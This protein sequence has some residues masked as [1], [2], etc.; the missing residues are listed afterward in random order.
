MTSNAGL[1]FTTREIAA[2]LGTS[3]RQAQRNAESEGWL[4]IEEPYR[5]GS[6]RRYPVDELPIDIAAK[7]LRW[8]AEKAAAG[9]G[10]DWE[11]VFEYDAEALWRE[12]AECSAEHRQEGEFRA[13]A[14][15]EVE[16]LMQ[17]EGLPFLKAARQVATKTGR[18]ASAIRK[19]R[20][21]WKRGQRSRRGAKDYAPAD[22][23]AALVSR[24]SQSG[25][26]RKE[27]PPEIADVFKSL[28]R[29]SRAP[30]IADSYRRALAAAEAAGFDMDAMPS[31]RTVQSWAQQDSRDVRALR[32]EG[33]QAVVAMV[34]KLRIDKSGLRV[35][36]AVSGDGLTLDKVWVKF[37]D[38]EVRKPVAWVF[39]DERSRAIVAWDLGKV[40]S[41][42]RFRRALQRMLHKFVPLWMT[43][44]N[45]MAAMN[46]RL[47][48]GMK[49]RK[50][51]KEHS[52]DPPGLLARLGI[53][54]HSTDACKDTINPGSK[55]IERAFGTGGLHDEIASHPAIRD[56][57]LSRDRPV[58]YRKFRAAFARA[59][60]DYNR[61]PGRRGL[62]L[63]GRSYWEVYSEAKKNPANPF[64]RLNP[65][66][67]E[68]ILRVPVRVRVLAKQWEV[69]IRI[70]TGEEG[71][72]RYISPELAQWM[73]EEVIV[74]FNPD[75]TRQDA[76]AETLDGRRICSAELL[77]DAAYGSEEAAKQTMRRKRGYLKAVKE[78]DKAEKL[79]NAG[80]LEKR[81]PEKPLDPE[82]RE[83]V[84]TTDFNPPPRKAVAAGGAK[85]TPDPNWMPL[86]TDEDLQRGLEFRRRRLAARKGRDADE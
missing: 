36:Q 82:P 69:R 63:S 71:V 14:L 35:G 60:R 51:F 33:P 41:E 78:K 43:L 79:L 58:T 52:D 17:G 18:A 61:R 5:G 11:P 10:S 21:G 24:R 9:S 6:R 42:A 73:G 68:M 86:Q 40:E 54:V 19:W 46:K 23:A 12:F 7:A 37:P 16:A 39:Q 74:W 66:Q 44:D 62:G 84:A 56:L 15:R 34:P 45:T 85:W 55:G 59:V 76:L 38:G 57:G 81:L 47:T 25:R 20:Y 1:S 2:A 27:F 65:Y 77:S 8:R 3:A 49:G 30:K 4:Y 22:R 26:P 80:E 48:A 64:R 72:L 70:G 53:E 32:R 13:Q 29:H 83:K 50:R 31:L 75:N 28:D 67:R